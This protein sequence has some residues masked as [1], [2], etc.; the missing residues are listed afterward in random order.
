MVSAKEKYLM[1]MVQKRVDEKKVKEKNKE[2]F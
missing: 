1:G 2:V